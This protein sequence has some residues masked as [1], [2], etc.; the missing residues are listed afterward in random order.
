MLL[1]LINTGVL[2]AILTYFLYK[3]IL[4]FID[5]RRQQIIDSIEESKKLRE[6][7]EKTK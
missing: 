4:K 7:F 6:E 5:Q 3:P 2:L 1:Y